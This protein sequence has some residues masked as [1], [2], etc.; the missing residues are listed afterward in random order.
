MNPNESTTVA[1]SNLFRT[2]P[3][4]S[5]RKDG[6]VIKTIDYEAGTELRQT[7]RDLYDAAGQDM[8]E[9]VPS[10]LSQ[11]TYEHVLLLA[12]VTDPDNYKIQIVEG[13]IVQL[14]HLVED[15]LGTAT[16]ITID[17]LPKDMS[18]KADAISLI[19]MNSDSGEIKVSWAKGEELKHYMSQWGLEPN[20][21]T[22]KKGMT[23]GDVISIVEKMK[24]VSLKNNSFSNYATRK[25]VAMD[26]IVSEKDVLSE[27]GVTLLAAKPIVGNA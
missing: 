26:E 10:D 23:Y 9:L 11:M 18:F 20:A 17:L 16:Q 7:L 6:R 3:K 15:D 21:R 4:I 5:V 25:E 24:R 2:N 12:G 19:D 13:P 27:E 14:A 1:Q 8:L 22:V